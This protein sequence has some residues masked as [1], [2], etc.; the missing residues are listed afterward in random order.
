[1]KK[2]SVTFIGNGFKQDID[3]MAACLTSELKDLEY[4][5]I[6]TTSAKDFNQHYD[7]T[8]LFVYLH[9]W[10]VGR[11]QPNTVFTAIDRLK[12]QYQIHV[13]GVLVLRPQNQPS[14]SEVL[15]SL[16]RDGLHVSVLE[17]GIRTIAQKDCKNLATL[18]KQWEQNRPAAIMANTNVPLLPATASIQNNTT[19]QAT[20]RAQQKRIEELEAEVKQLKQQLAQAQKQPNSQPQTKQDTTKDSSKSFFRFN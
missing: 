10:T 14:M 6:D 2:M 16:K 8:G 9:D 19:D 11:L 3:W 5:Y 12:H 15:T 4:F 18:L 20:I 17:I 1:M 7:K 13:D